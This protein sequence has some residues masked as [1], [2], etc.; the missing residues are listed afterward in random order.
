M[1]SIATVTVL[2]GSFIMP[3]PT[4]GDQIAGQERHVVGDLA[5]EFL[6]AED[7]VWVVLALSA[8]EDRAHHEA[9]RIDAR[10]DDRTER[11]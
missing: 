3:M 7:H 5:D 2:T 4:A 11:P 9:C 8:V 6:R 1:P 10:G